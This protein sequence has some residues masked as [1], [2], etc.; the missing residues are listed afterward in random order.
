MGAD[1]VSGRAG[2]GLTGFLVHA[3]GKGGREPGRSLAGPHA[4]LQ[5]EVFPRH[6]HPKRGKERKRS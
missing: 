6:N 3:G 1:R 2:E 5:G 4:S